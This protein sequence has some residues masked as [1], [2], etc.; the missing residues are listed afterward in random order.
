MYGAYL[1]F[2][3]NVWEG[4]VFEKI[5]WLLDIF[6]T[7]CEE[8]RIKD[9]HYLSYRPNNIVVLSFKECVVL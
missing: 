6:S 9:Y 3:E 7:Q 1:E 8:K 5:S 2:P 4:V